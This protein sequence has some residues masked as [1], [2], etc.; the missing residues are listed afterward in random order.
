MSLQSLVPAN[1]KLAMATAV[2]NFKK[3]LASGSVTVEQLNASILSDPSGA[4]F[5]AVMEMFAMH[6]AYIKGS[7]KKLDNFWRITL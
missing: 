6:L 2:N 3:F 1:T 7:N 4:C 5:V